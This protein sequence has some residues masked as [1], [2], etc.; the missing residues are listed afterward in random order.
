M[1][2]GCTVAARRSHLLVG[3]GP[4]RAGD[5]PQVPSV[6]DLVVSDLLVLQ[7]H[8]AVPELGLI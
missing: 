7:P 4:V 1:T 6:L 8:N 2:T 5:V 3:L